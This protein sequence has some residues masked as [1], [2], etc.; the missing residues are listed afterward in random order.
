[1]ATKTRRMARP[2]ARARVASLGAG[3]FGP[4]SEEPFRRRPRD[5]VRFG[6]ALVVVVSLARHVGDVTTTERSVFQFFNSLPSGL[7]SLFTTLYRLGALWAVGLVVAAALLARRWR[8]ARDLALS[9]GLAWGIARAV[10]VFVVEDRNVGKT[11]DVITRAGDTPDFPLVRLAVVVAIIAAASPYVARPTRRIGA[12]TVAGLGLSAMYLGTAYPT[13]VLAGGVV[14]WGVSA[15]V[16]LVFGSPG[17][18]PTI[19]QVTASLAQLGVDASDVCLAKVQPEGYTSMLADDEHGALSVKVIGRD[20]ADAQLVAKVWRFVAYKDSGPTLFLSRLQQVEHE[21][22]AMLLAHSAGVRVPSVIVA[23]TAGPSAALLVA[24]PL[25]GPVLAELPLGSVT[26]ALLVALWKQVA[27][28]HDVRIAH[29]SLNTDHVVITRRGPGITNFGASSPWTPERAGDDVAELLASTAALV[30]EKRAIAAAIRG[31]GK[32][33]VVDALPF[34]QAAAF[35]HRTRALTAPDHKLLNHRLERLR[36]LGAQATD[37]EEPALVEL[38]RVSP[39]NLLMAVGV[40]VAAAALLGQVGDASAVWKTIRHADL[41][42]VAFA[43][44]LSMSTNLGSAVALVGTVPVRLPYWPSAELQVAMSFS[45]LAIPA[46]GGTAMQV[47]FLQKRGVRLS[48]AVAAGGL[49]STVA[50]VATQAGL[51][52]I[53]FWLAPD[54]ISLGRIPT[55]G[56]ANV[57]LI[58]AMVVGVLAAAVLGVPR[59]RRVVVPPIKQAITT[60]WEVLRS[61]RRLALLIS[62]NV[63]AALLAG[64]CL[65]ACLQAYGATGVSFWTLLALN[66]GIGTIASLVPIPGGGAAVSSVGL[67]GALVALGVSQEVAVAAILTNQILVNYIPAIPGFVATKH[68]M[69]RDML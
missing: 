31:M 15:L 30:G 2:S 32:A 1:M 58:M 18:R 5:A 45:N 27:Q 53:A 10:G 64:A 11:F 22:Y 65:L 43:F 60:M 8:L 48:S 55:Q 39:A 6:I 51:M 23:G 67:S 24:R 7:E 16:H 54:S 3:T 50:N 14:G 4:A 61:P 38:H 46:V 33:A 56:I 41:S 21:A 29:G 49:L 28:L 25:D 62:G 20:E 9:G 68:L 63:I 57:L 12:V 40:L 19:P 66:I 36:E 13:D 34:L 47:R 17:G 52:G 26:S 69:R 37:T 44:V 35:S 42:W 59:L